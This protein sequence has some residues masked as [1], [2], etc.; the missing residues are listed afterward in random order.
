MLDATGRIVQQDSHSFTVQFRTMPTA[1]E[2]V[3]TV[4]QKHFVVEPN[5]VADQLT[6]FWIPMWQ[7]EH[8]ISANDEWPEFQTLL[9][10]MPNPPEPFQFDDTL[11]AWKTAVKNLRAS[12][13]RGFDAVSAQELKLI[14]D[15]LLQELIH[16]CNNY[17]TGVPTW[18]M[19]TRV[20]PLNKT[21]DTPLAQQSRPICIMSE[22]YRL[23]AFF[24]HTGSTF[25][26]HLFSSVNHW[27]AASPRLT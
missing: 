21:D 22:T 11:D 27:H 9:Q 12:S 20:C 2:T 18:F 16:V 15:G 14:P 4:T 5:E 17:E 25:L 10:N 26:A 19:R 24:W 1:E 23:C 3:A 7:A 13:A 6:K 8:H